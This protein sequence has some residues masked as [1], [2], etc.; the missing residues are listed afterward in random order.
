MIKQD[1]PNYTLPGKEGKIELLKKKN[2]E[3]L[4]GGGEKRIATQHKKG[5]LPPA[6]AWSY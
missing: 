2:A 6:S 5:N 1:K 4:L 3:A